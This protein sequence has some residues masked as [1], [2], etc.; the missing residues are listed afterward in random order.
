MRVKFRTEDLHR[1]IVGIFE[2]ICFDVSIFGG[3]N[4]QRTAIY[5]KAFIYT[6]LT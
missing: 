2:Q 4:I 3:T 1:T 6:F 5:R